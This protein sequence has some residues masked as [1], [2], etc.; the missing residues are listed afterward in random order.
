MTQSKRMMEE[1]EN[2]KE[3]ISVLCMS[4]CIVVSTTLTNNA[5]PERGNYNGRTIQFSI[6][7]GPKMINFMIIWIDGVA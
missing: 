2:I 4:E 5:R 7:Y 3:N 6:K 1:G